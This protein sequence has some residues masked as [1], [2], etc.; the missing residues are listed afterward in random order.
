MIPQE[1]E[2]ALTQLSARATETDRHLVGLRKDLAAM[3]AQ[4]QATPRCPC[5]RWFQTWRGHDHHQLRSENPDCG[6]KR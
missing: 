3:L 2:Q 5:G 4:I 1:L 6:R